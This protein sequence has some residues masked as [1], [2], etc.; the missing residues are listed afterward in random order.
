M[1]ERIKYLEK[2]F[3]LYYKY[4]RESSSYLFDISYGMLEKVDKER[5]QFSE[6]WTH[7][8][9]YRMYNIL[10][11]YFETLGLSNYLKKFH[12]LPCPSMDHLKSTTKT[13]FD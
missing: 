12:A 9:L 13:G 2:E 4:V 5:Q 3:N 6:Y 11:V 10:C 8:Y 7:E 1:E